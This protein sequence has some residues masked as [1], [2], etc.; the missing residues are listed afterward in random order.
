MPS[1]TAADRSAN[2]EQISTRSSRLI[3]VCCGS[4]PAPYVQNASS[5]QKSTV[6]RSP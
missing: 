1:I 3:M 4:R 2:R 6:T 5:G